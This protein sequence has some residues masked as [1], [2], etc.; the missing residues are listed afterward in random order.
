MDIAR[1]YGIVLVYYGHIVEQV[2]YTGSAA[3]AAQRKGLIDKLSHGDL[4]R[5][6]NYPRCLRRVH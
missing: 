1:F 5:S 2:M 4:P 6:F 3:A